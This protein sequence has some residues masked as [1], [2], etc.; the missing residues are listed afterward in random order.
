MNVLCISCHPDDM[1]I[2]C[3]GTLVKCVERGDKVTV[4]HVCNGN[5]GH[6]VIKPDELR[7]LRK[8]EAE[9]GSAMGGMEVVTI[10]IGDLLADGASMSKKI[11]PLLTSKRCLMPIASICLAEVVAFFSPISSPLR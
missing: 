5:M 10:D 2:S 7:L 4:C 9:R 1:E 8:K 3:G 11:L 6:E